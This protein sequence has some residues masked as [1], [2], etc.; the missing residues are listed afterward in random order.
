MLITSWAQAGQGVVIAGG[1]SSRTYR[2][3]SAG[4]YY[5]VFREDMVTKTTK[6]YALTKEACEQAV[7]ANAQPADPLASNAWSYSIENLNMRAYTLECV[8]TRNETTL[9]GNSELPSPVFSPRGEQVDGR[10][11]MPHDVTISTVVPGA[12]IK[13]RVQK[14]TGGEYGYWESA[15]LQ[16]TS[17]GDASV[18]VQVESDNTDPNPYYRLVKVTAYVEKTINGAVVR[19]GTTSENYR[20]TLLSEGV[21]FSPNGLSNTNDQAFYVDLIWDDPDAHAEFRIHRT[22]PPFTSGWIGPGI[23]NTSPW[24]QAFTTSPGQPIKI[25]ARLRRTVNGITYYGQP[26]WSKE[27]YR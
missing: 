11:E 5:E 13:Y 1:A 2:V 20:D 22:Y 8:Y 17:E 16:S 25:E 27:Y 19:S 4:G 10:Q 18:D 23:E 7:A 14:W 24:T 26:V 15:D 6:W 9:T 3:D 21:S 12:F